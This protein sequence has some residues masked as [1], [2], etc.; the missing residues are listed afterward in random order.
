MKVM[1]AIADVYGRTRCVQNCSHLTI[2]DS[3]PR[4]G[5]LKQGLNLEMGWRGK[6]I[7]F[8]APSRGTRTWTGLSVCA[9]EKRISDEMSSLVPMR[10]LR[11]IKPS[12][13]TGFWDGGIDL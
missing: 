10:A 8:E 7:I 1:A 3:S 11:R 12:G 5:L 13:A 9:A 4:I 2:S 6:I